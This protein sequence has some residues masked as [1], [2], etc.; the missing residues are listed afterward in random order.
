M[1]Y[2]QKTPA[3]DLLVDFWLLG[4]ETKGWFVPF[5]L[6]IEH[7]LDYAGFAKPDGVLLFEFGKR[8]QSKLSQAV[9][10]RLALMIH[11]VL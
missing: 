6:G 2:S 4:G 8:F 3:N 11:Y 10:V 7:I 5:F 9:T 1:R